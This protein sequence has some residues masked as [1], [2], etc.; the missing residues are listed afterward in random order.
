MVEV[1][2]QGP[3]ASVLHSCDNLRKIPDVCELANTILKDSFATRQQLPQAY[4][5]QVALEHPEVSVAAL[6]H[7]LVSRV[8]SVLLAARLIS[9]AVSTEQGSSYLEQAAPQVWAA[10]PRVQSLI[11]WLLNTARRWNSMPEPEQQPRKCSKRWPRQELLLHTHCSRFGPAT[12]AAAEVVK[13]VEPG[14]VV[15]TNHLWFAVLNALGARDTQS[16]GRLVTS[17]T[18]LGDVC[19]DQWGGVLCGSATLNQTKLAAPQGELMVSVLCKMLDSAPSLVS[20]LKTLIET[21]PGITQEQLSLVRKARVVASLLLAYQAR[22]FTGWSPVAS[23]VAELCSDS[24]AHFSGDHAPTRSLQLLLSRCTYPSEVLVTLSSVA[25]AIV[26]HHTVEPQW[27]RFGNVTSAISAG[28]GNHWDQL[29]EVQDGAAALLSLCLR[30]LCKAEPNNPL[31][32]VAS[33]EMHLT[34]NVFPLA[35]RSLLLAGAIEDQFY[36]Q[37]ASLLSSGPMLRKLI[38]C[39]TALEM[40]SATLALCQLCKPPDLVAAEKLLSQLPVKGL[41]ESYFRYLWHLPI[42]EQLMHICAN[43]DSQSKVNVL[44]DELRD[45]EANQWNHSKLHS[46][47]ESTKRDNLVRELFRK[48]LARSI[49]IDDLF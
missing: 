35:L 34:Q 24:P 48:M 28:L 43:T 39:T 11:D 20:I 13:G 45:P 10:H 21:T 15:T 49:S 37:Q 26:L 25:S 16:A 46:V 41:D 33:A 19:A 27:L 40:H 32:L 18:E 8:P 7:R 23:A 1:I 22:E 9:S 42:L 47:L 5:E 36:L 3:D 44:L 12:L 6:M 31:W 29:A 17:L 4:C 30:Q 38:R 14:C 2:H